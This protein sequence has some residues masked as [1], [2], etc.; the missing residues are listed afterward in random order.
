MPKFKK[1]EENVESLLHSIRD[2]IQ[3]DIGEGESKDASSFVTEDTEDDILELNNILEDDFVNEEGEAHNMTNFQNNDVLELSETEQATKS[4][5]SVPSDAPQEKEPSAEKF[6]STSSDSLLSKEAMNESLKA[7][8][9]LSAFH[10]HADQEKHFGDI[11]KKTMEE[12]IHEAL[13][14]LLKE[15]LDSHLPSLVKWLV[16][17]E[18]SKMLKSDK[19]K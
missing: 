5:H 8:S 14:P 16:T 12:V 15:W 11:G 6:Q 1:N 18:I 7:L 17:E 19:K 3:K 9:D 10:G 4:L 2:M 13:R